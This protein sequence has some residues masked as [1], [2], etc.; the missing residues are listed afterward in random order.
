MAKVGVW[1]R[2]L[3]VEA[4]VEDCG[5]T[6]SRCVDVVMGVNQKRSPPS[7]D[8]VKQKKDCQESEGRGTGRTLGLY[9]KTTLCL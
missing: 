8:I 6:S 5:K 9:G 4:G 7:L 1:T 2:L 3:K